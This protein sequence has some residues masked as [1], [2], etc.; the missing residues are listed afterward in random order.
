MDEPFWYSINNIF[1]EY[2]DGE[3]KDTWIDANKKVINVFDPSVNQDAVKIMLEDGIPFSS[4]IQSNM[5]LGDNTV[6]IT[7]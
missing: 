6:A 5:L 4:M 1:G 3:Y 2:A 7:G